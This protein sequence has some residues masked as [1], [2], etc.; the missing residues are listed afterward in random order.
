MKQA[1]VSTDFTMSHLKQQVP[2]KLSASQLNTLLWAEWNSFNQECSPIGE[3]HNWT[4]M[5]KELGAVPGSV[6]DVNNLRGGS[7]PPYVSGEQ[8][9]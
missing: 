6:S 8:A 2:E 9:Q 1:V 5:V 7:E 3:S 4:R